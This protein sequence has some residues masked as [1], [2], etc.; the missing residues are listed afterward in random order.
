MRVSPVR[1]SYDG[2]HRIWT[3]HLYSQA[4]L[5]RAGVVFGRMLAKGVPWKSSP[6][7]DWW[8]D[9]GWV[10]LWKLWAPFPR[11]TSTELIEYRMVELVSSWSLHPYVLVSFVQEGTLQT[12]E[13]E[14]WT[15]EQPK[16][17]QHTTCPVWKMCWGNVG[18]VSNPCLV[19]VETH[20]RIGGSP[21]PTLSG[22]QGN[23]DWRAQRP[24]VEWNMNGKKEKNR[25][26][27][28][29]YSAIFI[30]G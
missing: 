26:D 15:S 22:C 8:Q 16:S 19:Y 10:T 30:D 27:A 21:C 12:T 17:P 3:G 1:T 4:R 9:S 11:T 13:R 14:T 7:P 20:I 29:W 28:C 18:T 25:K 2:G 24:R 6:N 23:W 5:P